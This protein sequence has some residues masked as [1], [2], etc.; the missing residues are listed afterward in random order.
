MNV[1]IHAGIHRTGTTSLQ[2][3][4]EA[5]R[6]ALRE[7]G[8]VYPGEARNHQCLAWALK[9]KPD[10]TSELKRLL[11]SDPDAKTV[12]LSAEDFC[13][14]TDLHWL[15][16]IS[17]TWQTKVVFYL[18]RQDHWLMS[19]YNQHVKWPFDRNKSRMDKTEF[20]GSIGDFYWLDYAGVLDRWS[21]VL[22]QANVS[23]GVVEKG[24]VEDVVE[25]F[26][27]RLDTPAEGLNL[28]VKRV[29]DS[30]PVHMLEVA[31]HL[32]IYDLGPKARIQ[33]I[34]ALRLG[35][36]NKTQPVNTVYSPQEREGV[37]DRF[38]KSNQRAAKNYF[39]RNS[40]FLE[41]PPGPSEPFYSFPEMSHEK[42]IREWVAPVVRELLPK[43]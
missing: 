35:L 37:L 13:I 22:S 11:T 32:E 21:K 38:A 40:L 9:R 17:R 10:D 28:D 12:V 14:H 15:G 29:N 8:I 30:L 20:L 5:N 24:Q 19:W 1:V 39:G 2:M 26:F 3:F 34:R 27:A 23:A 41:P 16:E 42:F 7:R 43:T 18:R 36:A 31:R 25:D 33:M 4:L 6:S